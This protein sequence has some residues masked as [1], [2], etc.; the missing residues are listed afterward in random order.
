LLLTQ[1]SNAIDMVGRHPYITVSDSKV[2]LKNVNRRPDLKLDRSHTGFARVL[3]FL[4]LGFIVY[5]TTVEAAHRHSNVVGPSDPG[6]SGSVSNPGTGN[7]LNTR[8]AGC[9]ECLICQLHQQFSTSL[10]AVRHG[11]S[12]LRPRLEICQATS[13]ILSTRTNAP[14]TGRAPPFT[15]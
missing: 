8:L 6:H 9:G 4:L 11:S 7:K 10:I 5:G 13:T 15:S 14:R 2:V 1:D 12:P 3:S